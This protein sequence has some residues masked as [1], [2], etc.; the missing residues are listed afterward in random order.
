MY[1]RSGPKGRRFKSSHLDHK[2]WWVRNIHLTFLSLN[3]KYIV[4]LPNGT[5]LHQNGPTWTATDWQVQMD[6]T[7]LRTLN[8]TV[9]YNSM[10]VGHVF[11]LRGRRYVSHSSFASPEISG[12]LPM[13]PI[14]PGVPALLPESAPVTV[15]VNVIS[16]LVSPCV[17]V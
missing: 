5:E 14:L 4:M 11:L 9:P 16:A 7:V 10:T 3:G 15:S 6:R 13:G 1:R 8:S 2:R 17:T 12:W